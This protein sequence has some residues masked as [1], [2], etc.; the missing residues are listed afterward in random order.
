MILRRVSQ[1]FLTMDTLPSLF[2]RL[3]AGWRR[4]LA[5][6]SFSTRKRN[7]THVRTPCRIRR[8]L[9]WGAFGWLRH[10]DFARVGVAIEADRQQDSGKSAKGICL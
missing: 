6:C 3:M 9:V 10:S 4:T 2:G 5:E 7:E 8:S 1:L